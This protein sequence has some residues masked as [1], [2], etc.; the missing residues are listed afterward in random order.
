MPLYSEFRPIEATIINFYIGFI[1]L[2]SLV[3]LRFAE[4]NLT[5][6]YEH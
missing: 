3:L 5:R 6:E 1:H 4:A 2:R